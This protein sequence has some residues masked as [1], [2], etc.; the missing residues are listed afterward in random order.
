MLRIEFDDLSRPSVNALLAEH[1]RNMHEL[2]R[3]DQVFA[4]DASKLKA[5]DVSFWTA[6]NGKLLFGCA[7][8]KE[9]SSTQ[10]EI[11]SM[12]TPSAR[13]RTGA[14]RALLNHVIDVARSREYQVPA[15]TP[16]SS[17]PRRFIA[18][19]ASSFAVRSGR[20]GKTGIACS[21][22]SR[23]HRPVRRF[24]PDRGGSYGV[25]RRRSCRDFV[26]MRPSHGCASQPA[27]QSLQDGTGRFRAGTGIITGRNRE[28]VRLRHNCPQT[29]YWPLNPC[30]PRMAG[31]AG[32]SGLAARLP[33]Q[34]GG[35]R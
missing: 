27:P 21:C 22:H 32:A 18:A 14:G 24:E 34:A 28:R 10:G 23:S 8:L 30:S 16:H 17:Q 35:M 7:A 5:P 13:R 15:A 19:Q 6:W 4:L 29:A 2:S 26:A 1:I 9:L 3:P 33:S 31:V 20:T 11:K 25:S 12:R